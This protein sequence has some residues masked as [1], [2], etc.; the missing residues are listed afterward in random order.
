MKKLQT[1]PQIIYKFSLP[2][3]IFSTAVYFLAPQHL[4]LVFY[5]NTFS[6]L[7]C[8]LNFIFPK[9]NSTHQNMPLRKITTLFLV[10]CLAW[11][12]FIGTTLITLN[13]SGKLTPQA[14]S[15]SLTS[16]LHYG[17]FP[18]PTCLL[19]AMAL[20]K[21]ERKIKTQTQFS[22]LI[23]FSREKPLIHNAI[24]KNF[25]IQNCVAVSLTLSFF[26][27]HF[28]TSFFPQLK[29]LRANWDIM[30]ISCSTLLLLLLIT[31]QRPAVTEH[32]NI[33]KTPLFFYTIILCVIT[34]LLLGFLYGLVKI[35]NPPAL[36]TIPIITIIRTL[37][38]KAL[39][40]LTWWLLWTPALTIFFAKLIQPYHTRQCIF[41]FLFFPTIITILNLVNPQALVLHTIQSPKTLILCSAAFFTLLG[42]LFSK[43]RKI[44]SMTLIHNTQKKP[45][46]R[47]QTS[48][49]SSTTG[50]FFIFLAIS[51]VSGIE[52]A[53]IF[54]WPIALLSLIYIAIIILRF[55]KL[56]LAKPNVSP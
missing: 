36:N 30:C 24:N 48:F 56:E 25:T 54:L 35:M 41:Y 42:I 50:L 6:A 46:F 28:M 15:M 51:L 14:Y 13:L 27:I 4:S 2:F 23:L 39:F 34:S 53:T 52:L 38:T 5:I 16:L 10:Q 1:N 9:K 22:D 33:R 47:P 37:P 45:K 26:C 44:P 40:T 32:P 17:M 55:I 7:C 12:T 19:L 18:W 31:F 8:V 49:Q 21:M 3:V 29:P 20:N 43:K 11:L